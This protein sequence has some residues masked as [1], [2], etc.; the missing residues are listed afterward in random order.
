M[1]VDVDSLSAV[2]SNLFRTAEMLVTWSNVHL[3]RF[4]LDPTTIVMRGPSLVLMGLAFSAARYSLVRVRYLAGERMSP[5]Y[6]HKVGGTYKR[7]LVYAASGHGN[8][9]R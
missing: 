9:E 5:Q 6:D 8:R 1:Q 4:G 7:Q 3:M 2:L